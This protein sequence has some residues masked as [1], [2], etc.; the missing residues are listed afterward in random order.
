[1]E[2]VTPVEAPVSATATG[3]VAPPDST[4]AGQQVV[5]V[6]TPVPPRPRGNRVVGVLLALL[7][8]LVF[9]VVYAAV[10]GVILYFRSADLFGAS[11]NAFLG[12]A[13]FWVPI[14]VFTLGFILLVLI[15][16]RAG[17][18]A[19]VFGSLLLAFVV[20]F[21]SIGLLLLVG[22]VFRGANQPVTFAALAVNPLVIASAI[23][24]REVA[25]WLGLAIA[26]RGRRVKARNVE[27]RA[28]FDRELAQKKA[29]YDRPAA[30]A[31]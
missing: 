19:H 14:L 11:F 29:E 1:T 27:A 24:A 26:A 28:A 18:A 8:A 23:I 5:Y 15:V 6:Q 12:T 22:N 7:G 4:L 30:P 20:Y 10:V 31:A 13:F 2:I 25:I 3:E 17:W 16:N 9:A 21:A